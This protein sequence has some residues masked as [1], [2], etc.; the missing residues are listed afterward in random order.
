LSQG[1]VV[2]ML[3]KMI[4][5]GVLLRSMGPQARRDTLVACAR[6]AERAGLDELW[7]SDHLAI[8]PEEAEG[9]GGRYLEQLTTLA[10]L[11]GVTSRIGLGAGV[12]VLPY[13]PA[14]P[15]AKAIATIQE[16]SDGRLLL[17]V[18]VG[19]MRAEFRALGVPWERRG[20][21][22]DATLAFLHR[23]FAADEVEACGQ[24]FLF[25]PRPPRPPIFVGGAAPH[26]L[27]RAVRYGDGWMPML[28]DPAALAEPVA[29]LRA[30]AAAAGKPPPEVV[31]LTTLPLED[32]AAA[33]DR[34]RAFAAAGATR[35]CHA[36]R[37]TDFAAF[38]RS[39]EALV[40]A[41]GSP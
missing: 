32:A 38:A 28:G 21:V 2:A 11:A 8:P 33:R 15:T 39:A 6:A 18:G 5:L 30:E 3:G 25:L 26:A 16:L 37:Y 36:W 19:W 10:F 24:R 22:A 1:R 20:A 12:L 35:L 4:R 13:R 34:L 27:R 9:S 23:C 17:G 29:T 40:R 31:V 7:V 41:R 14:L